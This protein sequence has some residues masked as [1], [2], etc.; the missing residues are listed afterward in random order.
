MKILH[1]IWTMRTGGAE[2]AL[3]QLITEQTKNNIKS[4]ILVINENGYY[5]EL[6]K[7]KKYDNYFLNSSNKPS[8]AKKQEFLNILKNYDAVHFHSA[9]YKYISLAAKLKGIKRYYT[10]RAGIHDFTL[11]QLI[12]YKITGY[13]L[14]NYFSGFS[15]NTNHAKNAASQIY[16]I[17]DEKF[18][19]TY[20]G[21]DFSLLEPKNNREN[22][23][24]KLGIRNEIIIGTSANI[25][26]WKRLEVLLELAKNLDKYDFKILMVGNGPEKHSLINL[27][28]D[29]NLGNRIIFVEKTDIIA[30]YLQAMDIFILPSNQSESFGNSAVEAM[31][32]GIPTIVFHDGG[33]LTEHII[34]K[35]TGYIVK[36]KEE[37]LYITKEL[38]N[39]KTLREEIGAAGKA[40]VRSKYNLKQMVDSYNKLYGM[41]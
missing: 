30:D 16:K 39:S 21:I 2:R 25:R 19:V 28:K 5:G 24:D 27:T 18:I 22:I 32:F 1:I 6:L 11:K 29:Y 8:K 33:G 7:E 36:N 26:K 13:F 20:N 3:Y 9:E 23:K 35:Q 31:G 12:R 14:R 38:I 37:L 10:H 15:A 40:H 17:P 41:N 4:D 34:D